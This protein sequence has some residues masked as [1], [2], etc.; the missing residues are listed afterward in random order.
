MKLLETIM[1][2]VRMIESAE[3][4]LLKAIHHFGVTRDFNEAGYIVD[5]KHRTIM[6]DFSGKRDHNDYEKRD[7]EYRRG[8]YPSYQLKSN[9]RFDDLRGQRY[10][11]HRDIIDVFDYPDDDNSSTRAMYAFMRQTGAIRNMPGVGITVATV[12]SIG[13]LMAAKRGHEMYH[14]NEPFHVDVVDQSGQDHAREFSHRH[15]S[16]T[17]MKWIESILGKRV[18]EAFANSYAM[19]WVNPATKDVRT[20]FDDHGQYACFELGY[21][22]EDDF[23]IAQ[24]LEDPNYDP[25]DPDSVAAFKQKEAEW[26]YRQKEA[27]IDPNPASYRDSCIILALEDGWVRAEYEGGNKLDLEAKSVPLAQAAAKLIL[28]PET[29]EIIL[30]INGAGGSYATIP[31]HRIPAFIKGGRVLT[32]EDD[33]FYQW[34]ALEV[35]R[36]HEK[37]D[38][39]WI[40]ENGEVHWIPRW[41]EHENMAA[42]SF[43][44]PFGRDPKH[45]HSVSPTFKAFQH[46]WVRLTLRYSGTIQQKQFQSNDPNDYDIVDVP[47]MEIN[48]EYLAGKYGPARQAIVRWLT[49]LKTPISKIVIDIVNPDPNV[50]VP[51]RSA[52]F[53]DVRSAV[54][55]LIRRA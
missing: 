40:V 10:S 21:G 15:S 54:S 38:S 47:T 41:G 34:E 32:E 18:Y 50:E 5:Y 43:G 44:D 4:I 42:L 20:D 31:A 1:N 24:E 30:S 7:I 27:G 9:R 16:M 39:Y 33:N 25:D 48:L 23:Y 29:S 53:T 45:D 35:P 12:P 13:N 3:D 36:A 52:S 6:L 26:E 49:W 55:A 14:P 37:F 22:D 19:Y 17:I 11:D 51:L 2:R 46:G 28:H 8:I